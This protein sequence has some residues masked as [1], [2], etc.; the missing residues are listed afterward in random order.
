MIPTTIPPP[1]NRT[2]VQNALGEIAVVMITMIMLAPTRMLKNHLEL[3]LEVEGKVNFGKFL[4]K[5][6]KAFDLIL[7]KVS[8]PSNWLNIN[9]ISHKA[10][11][12]L[13][14]HADLREWYLNSIVKP[15][16]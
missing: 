9:V 5:I 16:P 2:T 1:V 3:I 15:M 4:T 11:L 14:L 8:F 6:F 10:S 7:K 13:R 12:A